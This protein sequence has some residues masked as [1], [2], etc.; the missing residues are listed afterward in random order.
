MGLRKEKIMNKKYEVIYSKIYDNSV[1][2]K[3]VEVK[4]LVSLIMEVDAIKSKYGLCNEHI[5]EIKEVA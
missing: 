2:K 3:I 1:N 5:L 4:S